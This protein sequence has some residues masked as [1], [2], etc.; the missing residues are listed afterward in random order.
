[1][2]TN[3]E[4][5]QLVQVLPINIIKNINKII[6]PLYNS[7]TI[8]TTTVVMATK[9]YR[10]LEYAL[11]TATNRGVS[12]RR[13]I[14]LGL[15][16]KLGDIRKADLAYGKDTDIIAGTGVRGSRPSSSVSLCAARSSLRSAWIRHR[17]T[18]T[19]AV[20]IDVH[21]AAELCVVLTLP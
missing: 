21:P 2:N 6:Q 1:M 11:Q 10:M 7:C 9:L 3:R 13:K 4:Q 5:F 8:N 16:T 19:H 18:N 14:I 17:S 20:M 12:R 15:R